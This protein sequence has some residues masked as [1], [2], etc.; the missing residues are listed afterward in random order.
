[1][2]AQDSAA[3]SPAYGRPMVGTSDR[4]QTY[5]LET[6]NGRTVRL[7]ASAYLV[8]SGIDGGR[9][10]DEVA[11][12]LSDRL[13]RAVTAEHVE[14][15]YAAV[16]QRV[17]AIAEQPR[18][19]K[20]PGLWFRV[21]ILPMSVVGWLSRRLSRLLHPVVAVPL[22][23]VVA[24]AASRALFGSVSDGG[25]SG[26]DMSGR[27]M[28]DPGSSF[29][30]LLGL[31][32][33][34]MLAH[35]L[36]HASA[37]ARYGAP[38]RDIGMGLYL[39]YPVFYND[40][41][42]AWRLTRRQRLV[43]DLSGVFFQ[44]LVGAAYVGLY[45]L[46]GS[47]LFY[48]AGTMVFLFGLFVLLPIFKFDGYWLVTDLL[49]VVNLSQQVRR[50]VAHM[51]HRLRGRPTSGLPWPPWVS[52]SVLVYGAFSIVVLVLFVLRLVLVVPE[53]AAA[54]PARVSGLARD[55][56]LPPHT[57]APGR[58]STVLGPTYILL[59]MSLGSLNLTRRMVQALGRRPRSGLA[60]PAAGGANTGTG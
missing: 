16:R 15:A 25:M 54:Y 4:Q 57:P 42:A 18:H 10:A 6:G 22:V 59:G 32:V 51:R 24:L 19:P 12:D 33:L 45:D 28:V 7:S 50:V 2:V 34:S 27:N 9:P 35:E 23:A 49:G 55:L 46:T 26:G 17:A 38:A 58:L 39:V 52:A 41:T 14:A 60:A 37:S 11:Q 5:L 44:F 20:P 56:F 53:L 43:I 3:T 31:L 30:P 13:G 21:R 47:T 8:L 40:V 36:G 29:L 1:V 48:L